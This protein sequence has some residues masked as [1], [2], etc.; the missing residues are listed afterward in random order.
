MLHL[1][2]G[3]RRGKTVATPLIDGLVAAAVAS[4]LTLTVNGPNLWAGGTTFLVVASASALWFRRW[5]RVTIESQGDR[6]RHCG[7]SLQGLGQ[8]RVCP[9]CGLDALVH[10]RDLRK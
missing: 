9:E 6:C 4:L 2:Q 1:S 8:R 10:P 3:L 7:Y 5:R